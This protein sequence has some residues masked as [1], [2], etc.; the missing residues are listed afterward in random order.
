VTYKGPVVRWRPHLGIKPTKAD[1]DFVRAQSLLGV[2][3]RAICVKMGERFG[4]GKPMSMMTLYHH[5]RQDLVRGPPG[6][7]AAAA[8]IRRR[9]LQ[10]MEAAMRDMIAET[11]KRF[12]GGNGEKE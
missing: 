9:V 2:G 4:L 6:R 5:F 10:N 11:A 3:T 7:R 1:H 8:G 12:R